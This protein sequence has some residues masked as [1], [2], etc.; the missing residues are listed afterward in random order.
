MEGWKRGEEEG[1][2]GKEGK[3]FVAAKR[4]LLLNLAMVAIFRSGRRLIPRWFYVKQRK[5]IFLHRGLLMPEFTIMPDRK[6][7]LLQLRCLRLNL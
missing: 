5:K 7:A 2:E 4:C 6:L 1:R 3:M